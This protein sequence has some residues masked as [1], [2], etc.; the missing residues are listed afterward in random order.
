MNLIFGLVTLAAVAVAYALGHHDGRAVA[1]LDAVNDQRETD[2]QV[3]V[4]L[5]D[6]L[7]GAHLLPFSGVV[8]RGR[9]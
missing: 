2:A 1:T 4:K 9:N 7:D 5:M 8:Q 6:S 3:F